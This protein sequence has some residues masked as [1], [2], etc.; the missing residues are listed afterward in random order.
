MYLGRFSPNT[1]LWS[2]RLA[3]NHVGF[4]CLYLLLVRWALLSWCLLLRWVGVATVSLLSLV[5]VIVVRI[6]VA[7]QM[8]VVVVAES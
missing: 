3:Q 4:G 8:L 2:R 1:C 7:S 6:G 5:G